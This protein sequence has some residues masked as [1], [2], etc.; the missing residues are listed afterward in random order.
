VAFQQYNR[1]SAWKPHY[2][3]RNKELF[4]SFC[5]VLGNI[6][7]ENDSLMS[8]LTSSL[9]I[10][11]Y[12]TVRITVSISNTNNLQKSVF[13]SCIQ[14]HPYKYWIQH[15]LCG[16]YIC[17]NNLM[18]LYCTDFLLPRRVITVRGCVINKDRIITGGLFFMT[19]RELLKSSK[20]LL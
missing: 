17:E 6:G 12:I 11:M 19:R 16:V 5:F 10:C 9:Q 2:T 13:L 1:I 8:Q 18:Y 14:V 4:A 15:I 3:F 7:A 20:Y